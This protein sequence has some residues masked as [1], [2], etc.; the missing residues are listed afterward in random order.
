MRLLEYLDALF[1]IISE[2]PELLIHEVEVSVVEK[3]EGKFLRITLTN[4]DHQQVGDNNDA[5]VVCLN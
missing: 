3:D 1:S 2:H 5:H 4:P